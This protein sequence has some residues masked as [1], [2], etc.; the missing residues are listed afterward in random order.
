MKKLISYFPQDLII[1][2]A[3]RFGTPLYLYSKEL[4]LRQ[5]NSYIDAFSS[6]NPLF[7]YAMKANSNRTFCG[8]LANKGFGADVVSG[9]ELYRALRAGFQPK[10]II[11]SGTGKTR[12]ELEY[13]LKENI[14]FLNVESS[15]ELR[16]LEK[17]AAKYGKKT[18][19]SV[20]INPK[21]HPGTHSYI[22]TGMKG[23]K[24]GVSF[25]EAFE[26]YQYAAKS[27]WICAKCVHFHIGSQ[28]RSL[29]PYNA[30]AEKLRSFIMKLEQAGI[31]LDYAN[32][33]GGWGVPE[34]Q[35]MPNPSTLL[36][37]AEK[38]HSLGKKI[39]LEPGRSIAAPCGIIVAK[40]LYEKNA[41]GKKFLIT[42]CGM[43]DFIRPALYGA[44]HPVALITVNDKSNPG[45]SSLYDIAGPVCESSDIEVHDVLLSNPHVGDLVAIMS[46][47]AYGFSMSSDYNSRPRPAE[48][49]MENGS[50]RLIRKRGN[51][52]D[53]VR[54]EL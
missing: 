45:E 23:S 1:Q 6:V 18:D 52:E 38:L 43:N 24:F 19:F 54:G 2:A 36:P 51:F 14:L 35:E 25:D 8:I 33:G 26:M 40:I 21:V 53:L 15:D 27:E 13:A 34:G 28:I 32:I 9:G 46:A 48:A 49:I 39:I 29:E 10:K 22:S 16:V 41:D 20:R 12:E 3:E 31:I 11:F 37:A 50:V 7:C 30:A 17:I 42:D 44:E 5:A 4:L 47:G